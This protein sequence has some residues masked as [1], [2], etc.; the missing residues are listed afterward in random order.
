M[1]KRIIETP[2]HAVWNQ[3]Y[4]KTYQHGI[5]QVSITR[6]FGIQNPIGALFFNGDKA[7][8]EV[9]NYTG[10]RTVCGTWT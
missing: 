5:P 1:G 9:I 10:N 7:T 2:C 4:S 6:K 3:M 8:V